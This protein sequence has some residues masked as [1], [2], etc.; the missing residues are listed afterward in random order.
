M[1]ALENARENLRLA[2][3]QV[4]TIARL[5]SPPAGTQDDERAAV[6]HIL[7]EL[8]LRLD[9]SLARLQSGDGEGG[10]LPTGREA[11]P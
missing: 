8:A 4:R 11:R 2:A 1:E 10:N 6:A 3:S 9:C 7:R 5:L